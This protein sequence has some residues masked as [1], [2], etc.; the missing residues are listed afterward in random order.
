KASIEGAIWDL[1]AKESNMTLMT[2][3]GGEKKEIEVG[4]S[5]GIKDSLEELL[6][7]IEEAVEEGYKRMKLKIKPGRDVE[8]LRTVRNKFPNIQIMADANSAY[9]LDDID[10]FK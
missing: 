6:E 10:I 2:A 1:Y 8:V 7:I 3:I 9:T 5:I 4:L